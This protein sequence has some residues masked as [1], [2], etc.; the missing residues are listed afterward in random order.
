MFKRPPTRGSR[1]VSLPPNRTRVP[2]WPRAPGGVSVGEPL[3]TRAGVELGRIHHTKASAPTQNRGP[4]EPGSR[5]QK[6]VEPST[7]QSA[8]ALQGGQGLGQVQ[9]HGSQ[10]MQVPAGAG[11]TRTRGIA[12]SGVV[13]VFGGGSSGISGRPGAPTGIAFGGSAISARTTACQ[14]ASVGLLNEAFLMAS[15]VAA[16]SGTGASSTAVGAGALSQAIGRA[17]AVAAG[18]ADLASEAVCHW[19]SAAEA[20]ETARLS[21]R[22]RAAGRR[23]SKV[24]S[25]IGGTSCGPPL[26]SDARIGDATKRR[27]ISGRHDGTQ[28]GGSRRRRGRPTMHPSVGR[29]IHL[30]ISATHAGRKQGF[31]QRRRTAEGAA[32]AQ[33]A[34]V[35]Q[36]TE[37]NGRLLHD[38]AQSADAGRHRCERGR[39]QPG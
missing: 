13:L 37:F 9:G 20:L 19:T 3:V 8:H 39:P 25:T 2:G 23:I 30:Y 6:C 31:G 22:P 10:L 1:S 15:G 12:R 14:S 7:L 29:L 34:E 11:P 4:I 28:C 18:G 5:S 36:S 32:P 24:S 26:A 27:P 33:R 16:G 35:A 17:G 21:E 38:V